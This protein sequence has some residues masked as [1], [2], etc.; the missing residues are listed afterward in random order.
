MFNFSNAVEELN[1]KFY[2]DYILEYLKTFKYAT[3]KDINNL[4]Y[5]KLPDILDNE[6]KDR[7]VKYL[8]TKL[9]KDNKIINR[10]NDKNS[11][12]YLK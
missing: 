4:I 9:R 5:P 3:R 1:N 8:L 6:G 11:K 7:R 10:G 12:W 2:M